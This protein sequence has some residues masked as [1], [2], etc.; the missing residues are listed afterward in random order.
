MEICIL[1]TFLGDKTCFKFFIFYDLFIFRIFRRSATR[2]REVNGFE[3]RHQAKLNINK[4]IMVSTADMSSK[5]SFNILT[6]NMRNFLPRAV[7]T[8]FRQGLLW[9]SLGPLAIKGGPEM[10]QNNT[11]HVLESYPWLL[12]II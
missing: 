10:H 7:V 12:Y 3:S 5:K 11:Y 1:K 2:C 9:L 4:T 8:T 6:Q